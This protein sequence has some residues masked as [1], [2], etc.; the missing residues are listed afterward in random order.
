[1]THCAKTRYFGGRHCGIMSERV[2]VDSCAKVN[3]HA[4][5]DSL[6]KSRRPWAKL[7]GLLNQ[8]GGLRS[9]RT[10]KD[11]LLN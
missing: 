7:D 6:S 9:V 11:D 10:I 1:M 3:D 4:E 2:K 5:V 8:A